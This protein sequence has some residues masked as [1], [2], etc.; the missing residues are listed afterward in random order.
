MPQAP[1]DHLYTNATT[2]YQLSRGLYLMFPK[3]FVPE[4]TF[5]PS[6]GDQGQSDIVFASSRD[7]TA[8][9]I[10][11]RPRSLPEGVL[12]DATSRF[13]GEA[14]LDQLLDI[15]GGIREG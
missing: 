15:G 2:P 7:G 1:L 8:G 6:W 14:L 5:G 13:S 3:R 11:Q 12:R 9:W 4:R 10:R